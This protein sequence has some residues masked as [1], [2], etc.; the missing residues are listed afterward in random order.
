[1]IL[2]GDWQ[3]DVINGKYVSNSFNASCLLKMESDKKSD[4]WDKIV[5]YIC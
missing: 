2:S 5:K 4:G 1:M 3:L